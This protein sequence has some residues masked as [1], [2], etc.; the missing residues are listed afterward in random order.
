M[1]QSIKS[2]LSSLKGPAIDIQLLVMRFVLAFGFYVPAKMK[3]ENIEGI[4][5]WFGSLGIPFPELN[6]YIAA[7]TEAAG[8]VLLALGLGTRLISVPLMFVM[9]VAA[10]AVHMGNGFNAGDNGFEIPLY[11]FIMLFG[12]MIQG[13]G[14]WS[15]D[16]VLTGRKSAQPSLQ[17]T[18]A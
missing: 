17:A 11:Y 8:V 10:V 6:A 13:S 1:L 14:R 5:E 3:W 15:V 4:G 16:A 7:S 2:S 9:I 12:L 18:H